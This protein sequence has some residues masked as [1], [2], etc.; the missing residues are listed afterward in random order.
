MLKWKNLRTT[1]VREKKNI[2]RSGS[3]GGQKKL[4]VY[5]DCLSFLGPHVKERRNTTTNVQVDHQ[6]SE[7]YIENDNLEMDSINCVETAECEDFCIND[8]PTNILTPSDAEVNTD[9]STIRGR[10]RKRKTSEQER[11]DAIIK[12]LKITDDILI[13]SAAHSYDSDTLFCQTLYSICF[14]EIVRKWPV[15]GTYSNE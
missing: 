3:E 5:M 12:S 1:Y 6:Q 13:N 11:T 10:K 2:G 7:N 9:T 15:F 4:W 14:L 8:I